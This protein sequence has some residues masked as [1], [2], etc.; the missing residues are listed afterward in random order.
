MVI[1]PTYELREDYILA[2]FT[3]IVNRFPDEKRIVERMSYNQNDL[4]SQRLVRVK[5]KTRIANAASSFGLMRLVF[6]VMSWRD[7]LECYHLLS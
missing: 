6:F 2:N 5:C 1:L 7:P 4:R 3:H